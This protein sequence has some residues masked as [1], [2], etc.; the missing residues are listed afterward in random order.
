[1]RSRSRR[2]CRRRSCFSCGLWGEVMALVVMGPT[3]LGNKKGAV[4]RSD[5]REASVGLQDQ[6]ADASRTT[7]KGGGGGRVGDFGNASAS[8]TAMS[9]STLRSSSTPAAWTPW[10]NCE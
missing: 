9:A 2:R 4:L 5:A 10:M 3:V 1:M 7:G 8:R 6:A